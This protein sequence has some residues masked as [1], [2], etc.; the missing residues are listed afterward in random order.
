M[1]GRKNLTADAEEL[2]LHE[3]GDDA[4]DDLREGQKMSV[5]MRK[6]E[7]L[8]EKID[9]Q[10]QELSKKQEER[11]AEAKITEYIEGLGSFVD[12]SPEDDYPFLK[13]EAEED[14]E[15]AARALFEVADAMYR[16]TGEIPSA[17][18]VAKELE[19]S[20]KESFENYAKRRGVKMEEKAE[21]KPKKKKAKTISSKKMSQKSGMKPHSE[22]TEEELLARAEA[23]VRANM[24]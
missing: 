1:L 8:E 24:A 15:E 6:I 23:A 4:P 13:I 17:E 21:E 2:Y 7:E 3:L 18:S 5:A 22:L 9:K 12:E 19:S 20:I 16:A 10:N 14:R 11:A